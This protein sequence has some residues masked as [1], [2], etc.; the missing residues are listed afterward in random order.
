MEQ[1]RIEY[2][3]YIQ[4]DNIQYDNKVK[5]FQPFYWDSNTKCREQVDW[6]H[7]MQWR[8]I[9]AFSVSYSSCSM[10]HLN[11][12]LFCESIASWHQWTYEIIYVNEK[13]DFPWD[14]SSRNNLL[15]NSNLTYCEMHIKRIQTSCHFLLN[16]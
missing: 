2:S 13:M 16:L 12:F 1:C 11:L 5:S 9:E 4:Y 7:A 14:G 8:Y 10:R 6:L 3:K 15:L